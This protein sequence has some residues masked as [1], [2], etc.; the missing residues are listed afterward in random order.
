MS[1]TVRTLPLQYQGD[2][3]GTAAFLEQHGYLPLAASVRALGEAF[4]NALW[5]AKIHPRKFWDAH[6]RVIVSCRDAGHRDFVYVVLDTLH[7]VAPVEA[8]ADG[9]P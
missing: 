6:D 8:P 3:A 4:P 5:K 7:Q 2:A 9:H 1:A